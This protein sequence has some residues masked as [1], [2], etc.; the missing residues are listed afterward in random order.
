ML[1]KCELFIAIII[2]IIIII[3]IRLPCSC[4]ALTQKQNI[5]QMAS[6]ST[7]GSKGFKAH[8]ITLENL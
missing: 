5:V 3:T 8:V 6:S 1:A 7:G 2:I 4:K